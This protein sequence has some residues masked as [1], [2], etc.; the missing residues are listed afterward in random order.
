M[1]PSA[2]Q[3]QRRDQEP[4]EPFSGMMPTAIS[5][6]P[7]ASEISASLGEIGAG[8]VSPDEL[9]AADQQPRAADAQSDAAASTPTPRLVAE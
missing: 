4:V 3:P 2:Q 6:A 8:L 9:G 5:A 7:P 1:K